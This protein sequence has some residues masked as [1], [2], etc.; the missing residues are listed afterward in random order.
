MAEKSPYKVSVVVP[1][2]GVEHFV[3]RC[4]KSLMQQTLSDVEFIFVDDCSPDRSMEIIASITA[5]FPERNIKILRHSKNRGLPASRNTGMAAATGKY[6]YHCDSDDFLEPDMLEK[7][8]D[9][10]WKTDAD[11]VW[12]D[13]YLSFEGNER[14][15]H[16]PEASTA[17]EALALMLDGSM[18]YNVWNKLSCRKLFTENGIFFPEGKSM[19]EDMTMIRLMA[20]TKKTAHVEKA[21]YHYIRTNSGAMTQIYSDRHLSELK[22]NSDVTIGYVESKIHDIS[23]DREINFFKL[24]IKLPFLFTGRKDDCQRWQEWY[25]EANKFIMSNTRQPMRTRLLQRC[26]SI[27]LTSINRFYTRMVFNFIYGKIYK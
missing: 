27:G 6:I 11:I 8:Y 22:Y 16:Q 26:A 3:E 4:V 21:L 14:Y 24:N 13:W 12:C 23:I 7:L 17:R 20:C 1:V 2:Y 10:A 9:R 5:K 15:M 18:K 19:G 25:P